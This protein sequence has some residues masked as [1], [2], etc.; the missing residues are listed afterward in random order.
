MYINRFLEGVFLRASEQFAAVMLC[1]P[2]QSGKT[3][4]LRHLAKPDREY[5]NFDDAQ[6]R[7]Q[8]LDNPKSFLDLHPAP[9]LIDEFQRVPEIMSYLKISIDEA[10]FKDENWQGMYWLTGSQKFVMMKNLSD[11]LAGR[12]AIFNMLPLSS[13]EIQKEKNIVFNAEVDSLQQRLKEKKSMNYSKIA[14]RIFQGG[15]PEIVANNV[16]RSTYFGEYISSYLERDVSALEQVGNLTDFY[17]FLVYLAARTSMVLNMSNIAKDLCISLTTVKNWLSIL[18]RSCIITLLQPYFNNVSKRLIK[19]PKLYFMDTGLAAYLLGWP[20]AQTLMNGN[21]AGAFFETYVVSEI[22]KNYSNNGID[23]RWIYYYRDKEK[24]EVDILLENAIDIF[25][26]EVKL[27]ENPKV[28]PKQ[29]NVIDKFPKNK[30]PGIV[31]CTCENMFPL[32]K[33]RTIWQYPVWGL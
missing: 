22:L 1:G 30:K 26:I 3:T 27:A 18:E 2:R 33:D 29:F 17:K 19:S 28:P 14:R 7:Q 10:K 20:N 23:I 32:N 9:L 25:P 13:A 21:M 31:I 5:I 24:N 6:T 16:D 15:M 11:S 8:F 4:M 12:V